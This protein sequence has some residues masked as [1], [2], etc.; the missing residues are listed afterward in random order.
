MQTLCSC[1]LCHIVDQNGKIRVWKK[2]PMV[3]VWQKG[4]YLGNA[5]LNGPL[6][7]KGLPQ[8]TVGQTNTH[9]PLVPKSENSYSCDEKKNLSGVCFAKQFSWPKGHFF[10]ENSLTFP[11]C[12]DFK[13]DFEL[14][15]DPVHPVSIRLFVT[16]WDGCGTIIWNLVLC[17]HKLFIDQKLFLSWLLGISGVHLIPLLPKAWLNR[18]NQT[19]PLIAANRSNQPKQYHQIYKPSKYFVNKV[20]SR[21]WPRHWLST[22]AKA[23]FH[24]NLHKEQILEPIVNCRSENWKLAASSFDRLNRVLTALT[25]FA[26][27]R[28][29]SQ[30]VNSRSW[31]FNKLGNIGQTLTC[32]V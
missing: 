29:L 4:G 17:I 2:C 26:S 18:T 3:P 13:G 28:Q 27:C 8:R 25:A 32:V 31:S 16:P 22:L 12:Y 24:H 6:F 10:A 21:Y 15:R 23:Q 5:H 20:K 9:V 19:R 14:S 11:E 30:A 1:F 7:K